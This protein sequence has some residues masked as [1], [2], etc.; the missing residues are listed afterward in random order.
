M[1][2]ISIQYYKTEIGELIIG[3]FE[4]KLCLLDFRYRKTRKQVDNR[5]K[6]KLQAEFIERDTIFLKRVH[7][8]VN[9]YLRGDRKEFN[10]STTVVG[11]DFQK[12]IWEVLRSIGYG[13]AISYLRLA[14]KLGNK[15]AVRAVANAVGANALGIVIPCHRVIENNGGLGGYA[16]GLE[17]KKR[18]LNLEGT[19]F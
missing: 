17:A 15:K 14:E 2:T 18:L 12:K 8:Q 6:N 5:I 1:K 9:E 3:S 19:I 10:I 16:G 13:K 4:D 7:R 11:T